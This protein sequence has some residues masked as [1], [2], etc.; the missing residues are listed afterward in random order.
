MWARAGDA[1]VS[2]SAPGTGGADA[3]IEIK[4][5]SPD[6][7]RIWITVAGDDVDFVLGEACRYG[8]T[9]GRAGSV[10]DCANEVAAVCGAV[11]AGR[12]WEHVWRR[13]GRVVGAEGFLEIE[14]REHHLRDNSWLRLPGSTKETLHFSP[15]GA[16]T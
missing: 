5:I 11:A 12:F 16:H 14:G 6:A 2:V 8:I 4:P 3:D 7:A 1:E 10:E 13:S 9:R 15:Y